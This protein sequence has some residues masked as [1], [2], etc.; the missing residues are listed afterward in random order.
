MTGETGAVLALHN[1]LEAA[2][3]RLADLLAPAALAPGRIG[4]CGQCRPSP[5]GY[6]G[7]HPFLG[8]QRPDRTKGLYKRKLGR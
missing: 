8:G 4:P 6:F 2:D 5:L 3:L 1:A 7:G